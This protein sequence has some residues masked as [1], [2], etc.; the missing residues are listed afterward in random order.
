MTFDIFILSLYIWGEK[1]CIDRDFM[2][3][4]A[5]GVKMVAFFIT[6]LGSINF[7]FRT[8]IDLEI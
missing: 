3:I 2:G 4:S 8:S 1:K 5:F 6:I 7:V